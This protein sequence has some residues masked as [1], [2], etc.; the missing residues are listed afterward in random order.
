MSATAARKNMAGK[1]PEILAPVGGRE[2]LEAA[3][4]CSAD[5]VYMGTKSFNARKN[6]ANFEYDEFRDAVNYCHLHGV[7]VYLVLNTL[8]SDGEA[9]SA[10]EH[11]RLACEAGADALIIQDLGLAREIRRYS[12]IPLHASTQMSVG[13]L[14]G[15]K[16]LH[17]LGFKRAVLPRE[18]SFKE[19]AEIQSCSIN[20]VL[21]RMQYALKN[22]R[23]YLEKIDSGNLVK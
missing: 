10:L 9:P 2:Q 13:T 12:D 22:L 18:L 16:L 21:S 4:R 5:A 23:C 6:A 20:T 15:L 14:D 7:K 3:V 8:I 17:S 1:R 19:I 11:A